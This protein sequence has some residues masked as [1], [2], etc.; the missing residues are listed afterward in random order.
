MTKVRM[1]YLR[2]CLAPYL[3]Q[4]IQMPSQPQLAQTFIPDLPKLWFISQAMDVG[5]AKLAQVLGMLTYNVGIHSQTL[6]FDHLAVH[7]RLGLGKPS[8]ETVEDCDGIIVHFIF[9]NR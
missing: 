5:H 1:N 2:S 4:I 6:Q 3:H 8:G 9:F 7:P